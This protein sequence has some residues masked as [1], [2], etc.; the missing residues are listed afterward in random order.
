MNKLLIFFL[1][2]FLTSC[3]GNSNLK[4]VESNPTNSRSVSPAPLNYQ[5][6]AEVLQKY[7]DGA[8][9]V[10]YKNLK[11]DRQKLDRFNT[12]LGEVSPN[13]YQ[14]WSEQEKIAFLINAYN[15]LTLASIINNYPTTSIRNI[16]GVWDR[17]KFRVV[18]EEMTLDQIEHQI[19]RKQFNEPR[20]H[21]ALVCA[22]QSCP[23]LRNE[24]YTGEKFEAQLE[25]EARK[26]LTNP[27]N[28]R[29]DQEA[30]KVYVSSIFKWFGEDFQKSYGKSENFVGLNAKETAYLNFIAQYLTPAQQTYLT[31][32]GYKVNYLNYDWSLNER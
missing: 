25:E 17:Q 7:V 22:A 19:L 5:D 15:S 21:V 32:G 1:L 23:P 28:F 27:A 16:F 11:I 4:I 9:K 13:T 12:A 20:I 31:Q 24:P 30:G 18:Q 6:Y 3:S 26:F 29:I 10:D 14:A 8:G 2:L